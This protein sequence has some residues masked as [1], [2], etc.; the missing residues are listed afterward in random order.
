M[1]NDIAVNITSVPT[2]NEDTTDQEEYGETDDDRQSEKVDI[3]SDDK[4][5]PFSVEQLGIQ[6]QYQ[7]KARKLL[8]KIME[9]P[10]ILK[11]NDAGEIM[12]F[13]KTWAMQ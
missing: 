13:G 4:S 6:Q 3:M 8:F 1:T 12:V 5:T 7:P 2:D 10:D 11:R 9:H